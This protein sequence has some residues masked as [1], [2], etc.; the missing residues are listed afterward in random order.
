MKGIYLQKISKHAHERLLRI[1]LDG[2]AHV[3]KFSSF[4]GGGGLF[5]YFVIR[6]Y[7]F[8]Q[9]CHWS[10]KSQGGSGNFSLLR[11]TILQI[12]QSPLQATIAVSDG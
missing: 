11:N 4:F 12:T 6:F 3:Y 1:S 8:T 7:K 9:G 10:G 5:L 2:D